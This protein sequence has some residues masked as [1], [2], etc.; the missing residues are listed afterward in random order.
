[1]PSRCL[2][3]ACRQS[4]A[5]SAACYQW[6]PGDPPPQTLIPSLGR[7]TLVDEQMDLLRPGSALQNTHVLQNRAALAQ[8]HLCVCVC[9]VVLPSLTRS[10]CYTSDQNI[11]QLL[12]LCCDIKYVLLSLNQPMQ[13][14]MTYCPTSQ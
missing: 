2:M 6:M 5:S 7:E 3:H 14:Y 4:L 10:V 9:V 8:R 13:K 1:M 11:Q 12:Q